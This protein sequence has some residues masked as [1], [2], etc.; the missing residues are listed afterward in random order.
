MEEKEYTKSHLDWIG[1]TFTVLIMLPVAFIGAI[2]IFLY[3]VCKLPIWCL[4][5]KWKGL[6]SSSINRDTKKFS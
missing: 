6:K 3:F 5:R 1:D 2:L 4:M